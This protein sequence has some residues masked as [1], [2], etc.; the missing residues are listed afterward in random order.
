MKGSGRRATRR[1]GL[2][3]ALSGLAM[4]TWMSLSVGAMREATANPGSK[5]SG[6]VATSAMATFTVTNLNDSGAGSLRQAITDAN[7]M[8]GADTIDFQAGLT[9]TITL[10]TGQLPTITQDLTITGPGAN[11]LTVSGNN[12]SRVFEIASGVT[13]MISDL[14]ISNGSVSGLDNGGGIRNSGALTLTNSTL[15]GNSTS[16]VSVGGGIF[17]DSF[18]TLT[19]Q[20]STLSGNSAGFDGGGIFNLGTLTIQNS[21]LSNNSALDGGGISNFNLVTIKNSIVANSTSGGDCAG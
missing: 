2:I 5:P 19:I 16:D 8:M 14:T 9:G 20:N 6:K 3:A 13:V 18:G 11:V 10:T 15:S 17:N 21:T 1:A 4:W 7:A 12:A